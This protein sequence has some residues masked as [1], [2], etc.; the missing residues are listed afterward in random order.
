MTEQER[1]GLPPSR[2]LIDELWLRR[3][4]GWVLAQYIRFVGLTNRIVRDPPDPAQRKAAVELIWPA[5]FVSW[6]ANVLSLKY[7][8]EK[9]IMPGEIVPLTAPHIDGQMG[10]AVVKALGYRSIVG[11]GTS[12]R[13]NAETGGMQAMRAMLAELDRGNSVWLAAEVPP[14]PGRRVSPGIIAL[15]RASGAPIIVIAAASSRRVILN[16]WDKMQLHLPFGR[17]VLRFE[18]P[19]YVNGVVT[20]EEARRRLKV[21]LDDTYADALRLA[22]LKEQK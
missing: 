6:H 2:G 9:D 13:Q 19:L 20:N 1:R 22:D 16:I 17:L 7:F 8:I 10:A 15:A 11:T 3:V 18:G 4:A 5:I 12:D 21:L 14:M